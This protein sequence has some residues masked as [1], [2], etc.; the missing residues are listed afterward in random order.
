MSPP[1][2][3]K[4]RLAP[5]A[6]RFWPSSLTAA[7][8]LAVILWMGL[9]GNWI[10]PRS[11]FTGRKGDY[12]SLLVH[13]FLKGHLYMDVKADPRL[14]SPDPAVRKEAPTLLDA[15]YYRGHY[16]LYF[17]VT[18]AALVLLPYA[19]ASG[20]DLDPRLLVVLGVVAGFLLSLAILRMAVRE[21]LGRAGAFFQ[22][23][24]TLLLA[25]GS[26]APQLLT[27]SM[28]YEVPIAAGYALTVAGAYWLYRALLGRGRAWVQLSLASVCLGLAVGCRPELVFSVPL[29]ALAAYLV[30]RRAEP[31][32]RPGGLGRAAAAAL[33]PAALIGAALALYNLERFGSPTDFGIG[34]SMNDFIG[35]HHRLAS[36]TYI[37]A[38]AR[39]YFL[40]PPSLSP[41]FPFVR[42]EAAYF[43]PKGYPWGEAL[44]GQ[45][46]VFVVVAFAALSAALLRRR[47]GLG[48]LGVFIGFLG[49]MFAAVFLSLCVMGVRADRYMVDFQPAF[50]LAG[51]LL[52]AAAAAALA[53]RALAWWVR[54]FGLLAVLAAAFNFFAGIEQFSEFKN[55]RPDAYAA[56]ERVGNYPSYWLEKAGLLPLGPVEFKVTFPA[57]VA[58][59]S[60]EPLLAA[61]TPEYSDGVYA[62]L[63]PPGG[64][65]DIMADHRGYG[66]PTSRRMTFEPGRTYTFRV[67]MGA[68][69][70]PLNHPYFARYSAIQAHF[71]KSRVRVEID[72][73]TVLDRRMES[74]D[75]PPWSLEAGRN[76]ITL[77]P[78]KTLF[79]GRVFDLRRLPAPRPAKAEDAHGLW[80]IACTFPMDQPGSNQPLITWG[81]S[82]N[83]TMVFLT[84]LSDTTVRL[85]MDE[86]GAGGSYSGPIPVGP[87]T[88]HVVEIFVGSQ[89]ASA[90]WPA[91]WGISAGALGRRAHE[92]RVWFDGK[93]VWTAPLHLPIDASPDHTDVGSNMPRFSTASASY[94]GEIMSSPYTASEAEQFLKRNL[95]DSAK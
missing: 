59:P 86:W 25:F 71:I 50:T 81:V 60:V 28:F 91:A 70:P 17:G 78:F 72:G 83:G 63:W 24:A 93:P 45:F 2:Q 66:G 37:W 20:A 79:T 9:G 68:L 52:G 69:Y 87:D 43:G 46:P 15:S 56:M 62:V 80:R 5:L 57:R 41:F 47:L 10:T 26:A 67:D 92:I 8:C 35:T 65:F 36:A 55:R 84:I 40:T 42:P 12:Y 31:S 22:V 88:Q 85:G 90:V 21:H 54:V 73:A 19:W 94:S 58:S 34:Y 3:P 95:A 53:G 44:H 39:W 77:T 1:E 7:A 27:R 30:W 48:R 33:V 32:G 29:L 16:Y 74:Y 11:V 64:P 75:A 61:G 13:G 51:V 18:P 82:G 89:A 6:V 76:D 38:N 14:E 4:A 23:F 49:W